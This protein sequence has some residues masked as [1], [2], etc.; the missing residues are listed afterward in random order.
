MGGAKEKTASISSGDIDNDGD[1]DIIIAN[2]RHWPGQNKILLNN[3]KGGFTVEKDLGSERLTS[4]AAELSDFDGDGD[5]DIA[6]GNDKAPNYIFLNDGNGNFVKSNTFGRPYSNTRN[7]T[8]NGGFDGTKLM[9][10]GGML[11]LDGEG[12]LDY[13]AQIQG[14]FNAQDNDL[15]SP[16]Q[17][18]FISSFSMV[19]KKD[20][21]SE[22][23]SPTE[24]IEV[25]IE[26]NSNG[27][28]NVYVIDGVQKKS[29]TLQVGTTYNFS[30][31]TSHPFRFSSSSDGIHGGGNEYMNEVTKSSGV[32]TIKITSETPTTLYYYCDVHSGMGS[33]ITVN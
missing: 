13:V 5:L 3:G 28:G 30:H 14:T 11:D 18:S 2:G 15:F 29:L 33:D 10:R 4:Y 7:I 31:P 6:V 32:T 26:A 27:S 19:S 17:Q 25:S 23:V 16:P 21:L 24:T 22:A 12:H 9:I 1:V 20:P 8:L